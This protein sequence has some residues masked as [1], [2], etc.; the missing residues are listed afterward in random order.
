MT[1]LSRIFATR[2]QVTMWQ[3]L[4]KGSLQ[5]HKYLLYEQFVGISFQTILYLILKC[6]S[7]A[8]IFWRILD[9]ALQV[10]WSA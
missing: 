6:P 4:A 10:C 3:S 9:S 1:P 2:K 7:Q 8:A 5:S